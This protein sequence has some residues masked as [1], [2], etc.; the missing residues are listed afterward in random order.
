MYRAAV[1]LDVKN[2]GYFKSQERGHGTKAQH[3]LKGPEMVC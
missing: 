3:A 1:V 2:T